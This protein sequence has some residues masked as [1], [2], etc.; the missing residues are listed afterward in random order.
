[1]EILAKTMIFLGQV[2]SRTG[3]FM[4]SIYYFE[5]AIAI[6]RKNKLKRIISRKLYGFADVYSNLGNLKEYQKCTAETYRCCIHR[7]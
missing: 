3:F 2:Q 5:N 1:M 4:E 6:A 7:K